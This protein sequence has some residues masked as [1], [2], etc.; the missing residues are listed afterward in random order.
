MVYL[1]FNASTPLD[2]SVLAAMNDADRLSLNPGSVQH[3][4]GTVTKQLLDDAR[5]SVAL[6]LG[7]TAQEVIFTSGSSE[8]IA[9][10]ILGLVAGLPKSRRGVVIGATEHK[11]V[12]QAVETARN[13]FDCRVHVL[14]VSKSGLVDH[15]E[16]RSVLAGQEFGLVAIMRS[17]NETGVINDTQELAQLAHEQGAIFFCDITQS[18]GKEDIASVF[19]YSDLVVFTAHKFYGPKGAGIL[20][21]SRDMQR[22]LVPIFGGGGQERGLRG[23][24]PNTA[25]AVGLAHALRL[26]NASQDFVASHYEQLTSVF[27]HELKAAGISFEIIGNNARR[28][29][30]TL[31]LRLL[32]FDAEILMANMPTIEVSTGSACNSAVVEPSHVLLAHGLTTYEASEC[33]R[34]SF[35]K[36]TTMSEI[37]Y[38][39][40]EL[41][42]AMARIRQIEMVS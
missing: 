21:A 10:G 3:K 15:N 18:V 39:V 37:Q 17:N 35:G 9:I 14:S 2:E 29:P 30:N 8:G 6:E 12:L 7:V 22:Q 11:A 13:L 4:S 36:Q 5:S 25:A 20:F 1:D 23:G 28:L 42:R 24:T 34:F 41:A 27:L 33:I 31:N 26:A 19:K 40:S 32:G 16:L 38:T